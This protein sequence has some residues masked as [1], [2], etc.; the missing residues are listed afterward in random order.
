MDSL[1]SSDGKR[2]A[3]AHGTY[4]GDVILLTDTSGSSK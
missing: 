4:P 2:L 1:W 3:V